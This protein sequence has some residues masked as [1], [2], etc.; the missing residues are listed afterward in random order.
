MAGAGLSN[1]RRLRFSKCP[2][3][4]DESF[5]RLLRFTHTYAHSLL[6]HTPTPS[7]PHPKI[8]NKLKNCNRRYDFRAKSSL[9]ENLVRFKKKE[10]EEEET[11]RIV[12]IAMQ[13]I[14]QFRWWIVFENKQR[15]FCDPFR[16]C[17]FYR[18]KC[19][20][21]DRHQSHEQLKLE[22]SIKFSVSFFQ[23]TSTN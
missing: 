13:K 8:L 10:E 20:K 22:K 11:R 14:N 3:L 12:P 2:P 5:R 19:M 15:I 7:F 18:G 9:S 21:I 17:C 23:F 1:R 4:E 6:P 16:F